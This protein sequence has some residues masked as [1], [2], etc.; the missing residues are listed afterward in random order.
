M[1]VWGETSPEAL[2]VKGVALCSLLVLLGE[3]DPCPAK[4]F[5]DRAQVPC[6]AK[7]LKLREV[8]WV[9]HVCRCLWI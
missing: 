2:A 4:G 8:G 9:E 5:R 1:G 6:E 3:Q 7:S